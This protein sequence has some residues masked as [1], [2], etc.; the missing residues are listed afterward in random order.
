MTPTTRVLEIHTWTWG[1]WKE[2]EGA[3]VGGEQR[4]ERGEK[5]DVHIHSSTSRRELVSLAAPP[6]PPLLGLDQHT[7]QTLSF[8]LPGRHRLTQLI[9]KEDAL[10]FNLNYIVSMKTA[11]LV[12]SIPDYPSTEYVHVTGL[13]GMAPPPW[14]VALVP[15]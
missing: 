8:W 1:G 3:V 10:V 12:F 4:P 5:A 9:Q 14:P 2:K 7:A 6:P 15:F 13:H 11:S